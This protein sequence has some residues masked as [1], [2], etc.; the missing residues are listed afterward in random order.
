MQDY[1][2]CRTLFFDEF[3]L[4]AAADGVRQAVILAAGLD[5]RVWRL[6]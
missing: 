1:M 6:A 2:A 4:A 5:A 3:F